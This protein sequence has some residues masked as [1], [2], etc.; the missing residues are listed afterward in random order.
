MVESGGGLAF[1]HLRDTLTRG[2]LWLYILAV[3]EKGPRSPV[4]LRKEVRG[5]YS[6]APAAI[7][8]Y[9]VLYKLRREGLVRKASAEF[10]SKYE[11]TQRGRE[12]LAR[13]RELLRDLGGG[14]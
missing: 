5:R 11:V 8:F 2:N 13:G 14:L 7:T 9:S 12:E 6:F 1:E 10:R 4:E 3:L